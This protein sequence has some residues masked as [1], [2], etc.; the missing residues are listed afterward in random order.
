MNPWW[1]TIEF[2]PRPNGQSVTA[3]SDLLASYRQ[4]AQTQREKGT[5][6]EKLILCYLKAGTQISGPV[7]RRLDV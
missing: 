7:P 1:V 4:I 2:L 6:F 5:Y 3:L